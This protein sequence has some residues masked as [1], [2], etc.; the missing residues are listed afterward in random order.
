MHAHRKAAACAAL[1]A[2][3]ACSEDDAADTGA[4][5]RCAMLAQ[6][7]PAGTTLTATYN[8]QG[9]VTVGGV[10]LNAHCV[11]EARIN[12]RTGVDGKPYAIGYRLRLPDDW[13]GRLVFMGGGGNDGSLGNAT[14]PNMGAVP[15]P[16]TP[17]L[18]RGW[19]VVS[20][21]GGHTGGSAEFALD[22]QARIDHA[23]N[24]Y[25]KTAVQAK[26]VIAQ[27]FGRAP[28]KSYFQGCSGGGRQGMLSL[29]YQPP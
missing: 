29:Q 4:D 16:L 9:A 24:A 1:L 25:D 27:R 11:V 21:D 3:A 12:E 26:L 20:T 2:L 18:Q 19:A 28:A 15:G 5:L 13:N 23:Y 10:A 7:A 8:A 14:G 17:A 22:P 6:S